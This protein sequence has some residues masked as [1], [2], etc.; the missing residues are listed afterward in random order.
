MALAGISPV[1]LAETMFPAT[2]GPFP[3]TIGFF[4]IGGINTAVHAESV[5]YLFRLMDKFLGL[6]CRHK[7]G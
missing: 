1:A 6:A 5:E 7:L 2:P 3:N 4:Q